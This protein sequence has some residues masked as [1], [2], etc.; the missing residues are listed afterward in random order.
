MT[1]D[2]SAGEEAPEHLLLETE[3]YYREIAAEVYAAIGKVRR[4]E[5]GEVKAAAQAVRDLR[6]AFVM[7]MDERAKVEKL[8]KQVAGVV[9]GNALELDAARDEIGRRLARLRDAG[10]G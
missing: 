4:G 3:G 10:G 5:L 2:F 6:A 9:G 8:R 1:S 7:V